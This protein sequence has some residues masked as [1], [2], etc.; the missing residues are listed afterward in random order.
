MRRH[1]GTRAALPHKLFNLVGNVMKRLR[2]LTV[3]A[4]HR[5]WLTG[6]TMNAHLRVKGDSSEKRHTHVGSGGFSAALFK[7]V[8]VLMTVRTRQPAHVFHD[9]D[10]RQLAVLYKIDGLAGVQQRH[11]L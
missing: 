6:V 8:N 3:G 5:K 1:H 9:S 4:E 2:R 10:N 11:L 7:D